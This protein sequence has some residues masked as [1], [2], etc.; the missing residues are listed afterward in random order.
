LITHART[1]A[2]HFL[3]YEVCVLQQNT[4]RDQAGRRNINGVIGLTVPP[5]VVRTK[6]TPYLFNGKPIHRAERLHDSLFSIVEQYQA[7]FRGVVEYYRLAYN[8]HRFTRLKWVMEQSLT[9]TLAH[10]LQISVP[11]VYDRFS[12]IL[13]KPNGP[14]KGLQVTADRQDKPPLVAT[15]GGIPPKRDLEITLDDQ[16][17]RVWNT[18]TDLE[19]RLLANTC[20]LCDT[21]HHVEVHHIRAL[22]SL[23]KLGRAEKPAWVRM[24]A[25]PSQ[26]PGRL[27]HVPHGYPTRTTIA[28]RQTNV[29]DTGELDALKSGTSSSEGAVGKGPCPGTSLAAYPTTLT[30]SS[31]NVHIGCRVPVTTSTFRKPPRRPSCWRRR[32]TWR[33]C[34]PKSS[35]RMTSGPP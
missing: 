7:E 33:G 35:S 13:Q 30:A 9:K 25:I 3:G 16:P 19:Q 4:A 15:W 34:W 6:C 29:R 1:E 8:V 24:M 17:P 18:R 20:E 27:P 28:A 26:N 23:T 11:K 32:E 21:R 22:R 31:S 2:A 5:T 12:A 10:K 14:Y